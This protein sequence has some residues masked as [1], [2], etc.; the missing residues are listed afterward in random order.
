MRFSQT[1]KKNSVNNFGF[2]DTLSFLIISDCNLMINLCCSYPQFYV[3]LNKMIDVCIKTHGS[4]NE[5]NITTIENVT[6][7]LKRDKKF[8]LEKK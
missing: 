1:K 7:F 3:C 5:S 8:F 4:G 2:F 6:P